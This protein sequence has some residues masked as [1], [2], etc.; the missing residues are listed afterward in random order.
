VISAPPRSGA[1]TAGDGRQ[2]EERERERADQ[3]AD[4]RWDDDRALAVRGLSLRIARRRAR[5]GAL[6]DLCSLVQMHGAV[7]YLAALLFCSLARTPCVFCN[8]Q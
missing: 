3:A 2:R 4:R 7:F 1:K 5:P 8:A 6:S